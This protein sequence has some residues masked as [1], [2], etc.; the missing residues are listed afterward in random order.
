MNPVKPVYA[1]IVL[2]LRGYLGNFKKALM[3]AVE[4]Y[5][6]GSTCKN[7]KPL[8]KQERLHQRNENTFFELTK[9][10]I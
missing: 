5:D 3:K 4:H 7:R 6:G 2:G 8:R 9:Q 1:S 10:I